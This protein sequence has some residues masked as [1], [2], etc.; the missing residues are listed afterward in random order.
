MAS[1]IHLRGAVP[2]PPPPSSPLSVCRGS[3]CF[4]FFLGCFVSLQLFC[5][6]M[7]TCLPPAA[8]NAMHS[9]PRRLNRETCRPLSRCCWLSGSQQ[10]VAGPAVGSAWCQ[11]ECAQP[12]QLAERG[13]GAAAMA[14]VGAKRPA[15]GS[16][17]SCHCRPAGCSFA[18]PAEWWATSSSSDPNY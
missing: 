18:C 11:L 13:R 4:K 17:K 6:L 1:D 15:D 3:R 8:A 5:W 9:R 2:P 12:A 7:Q 16:S 10:A 14:G